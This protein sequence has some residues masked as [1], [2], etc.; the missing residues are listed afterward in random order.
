[1]TPTT[2]PSKA[3]MKNG[4]SLTSAGRFTEATIYCVAPPPNRSPARP[5]NVKVVA[6]W[7]SGLET[8][9]GLRQWKLRLRL[10]SPDV[11]LARPKL[12][13]LLPLES[14]RGLE[15]SRID[16]RKLT[17]LSHDKRLGEINCFIF[18]PS[19]RVAG[20]QVFA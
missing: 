1:M 4:S 16:S 10:A 11:R 8:L 20:K 13:R 7:Q 9:S 6:S 18:T 2:Q 5:D 17:K 3:E 15:K 14:V 12:G 19:R